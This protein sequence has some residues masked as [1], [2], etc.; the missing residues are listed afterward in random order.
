M[1]GSS[2]LHTLLYNRIA[3]SSRSLRVR[4]KYAEKLDVRGR[5][6]F[7]EGGLVRVVIVARGG[8]WD[9]LVGFGG[10]LC[11]VGVVRWGAGERGVEGGGGGGAGGGRKGEGRKVGGRVS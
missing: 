11:A 2:I 6:E 10:V 8:Q 5:S 4:A 7:L 3:H 9:V 1:D